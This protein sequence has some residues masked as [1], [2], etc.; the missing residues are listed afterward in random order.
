MQTGNGERQAPRVLV[1][2]DE[3][4]QAEVL[5]HTLTEAGFRVSVL[6]DGGEVVDWV[7]ANQPDAVLLDIVL[8]D[9]DGFELCRRIREFST[10]PLIMTTGRV[11]EID[12]LRGLDLGADDYICKPVS[13]PEVIARLRALLRRAVDWKHLSSLS[14]LE[15]QADR[16][17]A[18]WHGQRL[19]LTSVEFRLLEALSERPGWVLAREQLLDLLYPDGRVVSDRTIDSHVKNLRRKFAAA[20][21]EPVPIESVY[22]AGYRYRDASAAG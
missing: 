18:T 5:T 17:D 21:S 6:P 13:P 7:R 15:L 8:P 16:L 4:I 12:R 9:V 3:P 11:E 14:G 19:D 22:G 10:V 1:V 20:S 2:E